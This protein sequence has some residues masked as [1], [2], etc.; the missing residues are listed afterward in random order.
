MTSFKKL[1]IFVNDTLFQKDWRQRGE[2]EYKK[3]NMHQ[4][5]YTLV[6]D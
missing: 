5:S 2:W 4:V 3:N 6:I 1:E